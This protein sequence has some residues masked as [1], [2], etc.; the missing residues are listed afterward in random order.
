MSI[1][2]FRNQKDGKALDKG[3]A[4]GVEESQGEVTQRPSKRKYFKD[5][6]RSD[7]SNAAAKSSKM[8]TENWPLDLAMKVMGDLDKSSIGQVEDMKAWLEWTKRKVMYI[9]AVNPHEQ[10]MHT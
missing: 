2:T 5:K 6:K 10:N 4:D 3:A 1:T 8:R 7:G 9:H